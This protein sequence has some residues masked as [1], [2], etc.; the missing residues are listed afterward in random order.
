MA[1]TQSSA[2]FHAKYALP[3]EG[4]GR[5]VNFLGWRKAIFEPL[6]PE[7]KRPD[8]RLEVGEAPASVNDRRRQTLQ[9]GN[10]PVASRQVERFVGCLRG[11]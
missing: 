8:M 7:P 1:P 2:P 3:G 11:A 4:R 9:P 5:E 10:E 6:L